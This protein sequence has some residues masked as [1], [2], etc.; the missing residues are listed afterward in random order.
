MKIEQRPFGT[1]SDAHT[2]TLYTLTNNH[3]HSVELIDRGATILSVNVPDRD[4][5]LA[6]VNLGFPS[7]DGYLQ[8]HPYFGS[9]VGRVCNRIAGGR[10]SIDGRQYQVAKNLGEHHL[11]G[12]LVAFDALLWTAQPVQADSHVGVRM[13]L[14]SPDGDE[15]FPGTLDTT[16]EFSW[17]DANELTYSFT[18]QTD[19]PTHVNLT[20]HAYWNLA[21]VSAGAGASAKD[22]RGHVVT[23]Q[24]DRS[25]Q[26]DD[27]LIPTGQEID[28]AGTDLNFREP[29]AIGD[30]IDR[31]PATKGY[32]HCYV[33]RGPAGDL[34]L[35]AHAVDPAS[36]RSMEVLTTQPC[37]QLYTG[38]HLSGQ[39]DAGGFS[40]HTGFCC[41]TQHPPDAAN[42]EVFKSTRLNPG[43]TLRETTTHRFGIA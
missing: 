31:L 42:R 38:N 40:Q 13:R 17:N 24:A 20:N 2:V 26:V 1:T 33:L 39:Q 8:R 21:G 10:F 5:K 28:V 25:L 41:E 32:D 22:V 4:G 35:A 19:A 36:G 34:R 23:I 14:V 43:E 3:G 15:G 29:T 7:L 30:R 11:H 9:T 18:A 6:N 27:D 16:V 12:G 37:M